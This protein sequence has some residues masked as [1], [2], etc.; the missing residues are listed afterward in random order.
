MAGT[1]GQLTLALRR[2][3]EKDTDADENE[4]FIT[5][6]STSKVIQQIYR[7]EASIGSKSSDTNVRVYSGNSITNVPVRPDPPAAETGN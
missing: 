5:D 2:L 1:M 6:V 7:T 3:G 4:Q